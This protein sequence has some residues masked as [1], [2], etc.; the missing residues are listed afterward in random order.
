M[1]HEIRT[2]MNAVI[3]LSSLLELMDLPP[4]ALDHVATIRTASDSLLS[5]I[6][7]ILDFSKIESGHLQLEARPLDL[8]RSLEASVDLVSAKAAS[9][10]LGLHTYI[11]PAVPRWVRGDEARLRQIILNLLGN[12]VKFTDSGFVVLSAQPDPSGILFS[13]RDTGIGIPQDRL[14]TLFRSFTQLDASITRQFG[15][16]GLGLAIARRLAELMGGRI[17]AESVPGRGSNFQVCLPLSAVTSEGPHPQAL[18]VETRSCLLVAPPCLARDILLKSLEGAHLAVTLVSTVPEARAA[19]HDQRFDLILVDEAASEGAGRCLARELW[20]LATLSSV[21]L[22]GAPSSELP[23]DL[24]L[25]AKPIRPSHLQAWLASVQSPALAPAPEPAPPPVGDLA[26]SLPLRILIADDNAINRKVM[27]NMLARLGYSVEQATNGL[28]VLEAVRNRRLD[29]IFLDLQMP[30]MDGLTAA[31][32]IAKE[33]PSERPRLV[34]LTANTFE[35]DR[36]ACFAAGMDDFVPKPI[37]IA[38]LQRAL[39]RSAPTSAL[40]GSPQS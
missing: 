27:S 37:G 29:L 36:Q 15:G 40:T 3:G 11:H 22:L 33:P 1:S 4:E 23:A 35:R 13:V 32:M 8:Y 39:L 38:E 14:D 7:D 10:R 18:A 25:L 30:E 2:P 5:L 9:K 34:A 17:W 31:R 6:N 16:T 19:L 24:P 26:A 20:E 21:A 28:E 12:A